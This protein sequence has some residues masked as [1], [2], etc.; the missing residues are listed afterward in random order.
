MINLFR[1]Q[2]NFLKPCARRFSSSACC[3][4]I[5][6][7]L[8]TVTFAPSSSRNDISPISSRSNNLN[9]RKHLLKPVIIFQGILS[10]SKPS[11]KARAS[12]LPPPETSMTSQAARTLP[13]RLINACRI[14]SCGG[15][16]RNAFLQNNGE[17]TKLQP[18]H[19]SKMLH[20]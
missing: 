14:A 20:A 1:S 11:R 16:L 9:N 8:A 10:L 7:V 3:Q 18:K 15:I 13:H 2:T 12:T 5:V 4:A 19:A 17:F 6:S